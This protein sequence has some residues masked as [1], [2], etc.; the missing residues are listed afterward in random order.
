MNNPIPCNIYENPKAIELFGITLRPGGY[1]ITKRAADFCGLEAGSRVL[2]IGCGVGASVEYLINH[3]GI[4]AM[5]IDNSKG[6]LRIGRKRNCSIPIMY[7]RAEGTVFPSETMD[8]VL[9]ECTL[10]HVDNIGRVL[11]ECSR[12][13]K[14]NG[15]LILS[16]LYMR[17]AESVS[18]DINAV[19]S[20]AGILTKEELYACVQNMG[21]KIRLFEDHSK[22]LID[23]LC[24]IIFKYGS[25]ADFYRQTGCK[26]EFCNAETIWTKK[27]IGYYL[28]IATKS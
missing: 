23:V 24:S 17:K 22:T 27:K 25:M 5:G 1:H 19:S 11:G 18:I 8:A 28:L 2:D 4:H 7:G 10:S 21:F 3:Y 12:I 26:N 14:R 13:L 6:M 9:C 15:Y 20:I 16:D